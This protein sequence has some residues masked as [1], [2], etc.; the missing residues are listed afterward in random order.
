MS[1]Y[2]EQGREVADRLHATIEYSDY[3]ALIN[4]IDDI[5]TLESR[6]RELEYMWAELEDVPMDPDTECIEEPFYDLFPAGT[7]REEI[8]KWFDERYSKGVAYLLYNDGVD[9]TSKTTMLLYYSELCFSCETHDCAYNSAGEC[10]YP[11]VH[12]RPPIITDDDGCTEGVIS[13]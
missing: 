10:R 9:R 12:H 3:M 13:L 11:M 5:D 7:H 2:K 6:D 8:W 1:Y 4:A